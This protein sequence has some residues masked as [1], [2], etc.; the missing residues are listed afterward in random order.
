M[1]DWVDQIAA[2]VVQK[3]RWDRLRDHDTIAA[4]LRKARK[5]ALAEALATIDLKDGWQSTHEVHAAIR[6]L[7]EAP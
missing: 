2:S 1:T 5:D 7:M 4:A 6:K 3:L